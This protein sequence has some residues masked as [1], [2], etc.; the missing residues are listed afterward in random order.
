MG[1]CVEYVRV[2]VF[3]NIFAMYSCKLTKNILSQ[4]SIRC[5]Q[6]FSSII[7]GTVSHIFYLGSRSNFM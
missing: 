6:I 3:P 1:I 4:Y 2:C 7:K 5:F